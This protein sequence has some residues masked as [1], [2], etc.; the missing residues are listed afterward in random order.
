MKKLIEEIKQDIR[1]LR[2]SHFHFCPFAIFEQIGD[3]EGLPTK[4]DKIKYFV[5]WVDK[6]AGEDGGECTCENFDQVNDKLNKLGRK[7]G[8]EKW[9]IK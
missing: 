6:H 3:Q 7:L 5:E 4:E 8:F 1:D 2:D 9:D